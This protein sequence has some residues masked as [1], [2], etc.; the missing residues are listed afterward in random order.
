MN[1][2][3]TGGKITKSA[4]GLQVVFCLPWQIGYG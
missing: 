4:R 2:W 3:K 1:V